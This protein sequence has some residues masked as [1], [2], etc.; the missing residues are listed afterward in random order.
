MI[1]HTKYFGKIREII[2]KDEE[3]FVFKGKNVKDF[4]CLLYKKYGE[5]LRVHMEEKTKFG[6]DYALLLCGTNI[7][8]NLDRIIKDGDD[9]IFMPLV[10]GG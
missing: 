7:G 3:S 8:D 5:K 1:V 10:I 9:M 4:L 6:E 2:G